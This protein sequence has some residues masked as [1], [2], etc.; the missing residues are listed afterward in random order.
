VL[1]L[2][3]HRLAI[4]FPGNRIA[5]R[6]AEPVEPGRVEQEGL[7][8]FGLAAEDLLG[9]VIEDIA[10][11][12]VEAIDRGVEIVLALHRECCELQG[13]DPALRARIEQRDLGAREVQAGHLIEELGRLPRRETQVGSPQ[14]QHLPPA[15]QE[16]QGQRGIG[17]AGDDQVQ[18]RWQMRQQELHAPVD[19]PRLD[20][21]IV[22]QHQGAIGRQR[23]QLV[24]QRAEDRLDR[25]RVGRPQ[26]RGH[27]RPQAWLHRL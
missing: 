14:F 7:H 3:E 18:G 15:A 11:A 27:L 16:R 1:E 4:T 12:T 17:V 24:E 20:G 5:Q 13:G 22:I 9:E 25:R 26:Q 21:V 19:R 6:T 23:G 8:R 10:V 2:I